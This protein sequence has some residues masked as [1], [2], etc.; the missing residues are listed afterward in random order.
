MAPELISNWREAFR[1]IDASRRRGNRVGLVPT[2]GALHEGHLS[3]V[4]AA[5]RVSDD[6][7]VSVFVNPTQFN[8][9]A[10]L[11][12]Y[13]RT[14]EADLA[15]LA[16]LSVPLVFAPEVSEVYPPGCTTEIKPPRVADELEGRFRPGHFAGVATIVCK[17]FQILPADFAFF[18][19]KDYQQCLVI[20]DMVRD[21]NIPVE[22]RF[23]P[24][25]RERDGLA[26][27][28]RNQHL[29][30]FEREQALGIWR[31]IQ[32]AQRS[33]RAGETRT[34]ELERQA[35]E[36]M[37]QAGISQID[38]VA[39]RDPERLATLE[40]ATDDARLLIAAHVGSTRLIDNARLGPTL[41]AD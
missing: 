25:V 8:S 13:P 41:A 24:T 12:R 4:E 35:G 23:C 36:V 26:L 31:A 39:L 9:A 30:S 7:V 2:M 21:L 37:K 40:A 22:L 15:H 17:L 11:Q 28:S 16:K 14:L 29:S 6:V 10:D 32:Q 27:S 33:F 20:R 3:L 19:E 34:D 1:R 5:Q 38:Y 18:G